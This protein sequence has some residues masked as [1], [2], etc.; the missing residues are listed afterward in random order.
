ME[1]TFKEICF[2]WM[3]L[4]KMQSW[5]AVA[6][7]VEYLIGKGIYLDDAKCFEQVCNLK[8]FLECWL[9]D[10]E[11]TACQLIRNGAIIFIKN[12]VCHS[13]AKNSI[14]FAGVNHN[15]HVK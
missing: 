12:F 10:E 13:V 6:S 8:T 14:F 4:S 15:A 2:E 5:N 9:G 11:F 7:C 1:E 3:S